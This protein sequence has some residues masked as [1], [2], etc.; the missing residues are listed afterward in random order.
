MTQPLLDPR[1]GIE[2]ANGDPVTLRE[3]LDLLYGLLPEYAVALSGALQTGDTTGLHRAAHSLS[4]A[5]S[6]CETVALQTAARALET[7]C[8]RD[9]SADALPGAVQTVL[10]HIDRL[11]QL[12]QAGTLPAARADLDGVLTQ[13]G[14]QYM[15]RNAVVVCDDSRDCPNF[16]KVIY[17]SRGPVDV[18]HYS[19]PIGQDLPTTPP[20]LIR[21]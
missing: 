1:V 19:C 3:A 15:S 2:R 8:L 16:H 18:V 20:S 4:G 10:C 12:R 13:Q 7:L 14:A 9:D 5:S 11:I 21:A 6:Y 17:G